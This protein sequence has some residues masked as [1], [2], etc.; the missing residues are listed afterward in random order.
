[1]NL[2]RFLTSPNGQFA[3][4]YVEMVVAMFAGM[5]VLGGLVE[6]ALWA[7]GTSTNDLSHTAPAV[8]LLAM[9]IEMTLPMVAWMRYRGHGWGTNAEMA[10][11]M[12]LPTF[13][14]IALMATDLVGFWSAMSIEHPLML[15][16][17]FGAMLLR[18]D[19]YSR[20][21]DHSAPQAV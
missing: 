13:L 14:V 21:L 9:A 17:M 18:R 15:V 1:M 12:L 20:H 4:H 6:G 8:L 2:N 19:E 16:S 3:R 11:S 7:S 10:A 5:I